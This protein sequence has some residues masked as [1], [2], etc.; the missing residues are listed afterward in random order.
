MMV[1]HDVV[2]AVA[3]VVVANDNRGTGLVIISDR[4]ITIVCYHL[5]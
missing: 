3:G 5:E 2:V 1:G 4:I